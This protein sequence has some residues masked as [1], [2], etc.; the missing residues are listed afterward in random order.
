MAGELFVLSWA[1]LL[2]VQSE[3]VPLEAGTEEELRHL[4]GHRH[5]AVVIDSAG[6]LQLRLR[7]R[8]NRPHG[9]LLVRPCTCT[10]PG[11]PLM[12]APRRVQARLSQMMPGQR[13]FPASEGQYLHLFRQALKLLGVPQASSFG[14]KAFRAGRATQLAEEGKPV[15]VIMMMGEWRS[16]AVLNYV[17]P[18]ALDAGVFWQEVQQD[19]V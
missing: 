7:C 5:S 14:F 12:C 17:S 6:N 8:K 13:L 4:P 16:A 9:S 18:D 3:G 11:G 19:S 15:H 1:F 10:L 2:R